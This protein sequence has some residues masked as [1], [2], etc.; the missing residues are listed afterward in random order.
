M[1]TNYVPRNINRFRFKLDTTKPTAIYLPSKSEGGL[2][3]GW[4]IGDPDLEGYLELYSDTSIRFGDY[5]ILFGFV[6]DDIVQSDGFFEFKLARKRTISHCG[7][8]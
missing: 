5:G 2:L 8:H 3:E 1:R 6:I 7:G 4:I